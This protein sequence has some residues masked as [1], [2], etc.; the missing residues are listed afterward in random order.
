MHVTRLIKKATVGSAFAVLAAALMLGALASTALAQQQVR[1]GPARAEPAPPAKD[2]NQRALEIYEFRRN[3][4]SGPARG[5]EIYFYK[6]WMCH[7]ENAQGGAPKLVGLYKRANLISGAPV[8]DENVKAKILTGSANMPAYRHVLNEG[9]LADLMA[10]LK[11]EKCCWNSDAPP[12]N[13]RYKGANAPARATLYE[14]L[15]GGPKG[16]VKNNRGEAIEGIM[17]QLIADDTAIR[18]TVYSR[19][20]GQYEFP[21]VPTGSYTLR[22]AK[23]KEFY[24][25]SRTKVEVKGSET[26]ADITLLRITPSEFLPPF[27]EIAAQLTGSEWLQNLP[28]T[29]EEKKT[30]TVYCNFCHEYQQIFRNRYDESGWANIIFRMTHGAGSPLINIRNPG[31]LTAED[32]AKFAK[33]LAS[34]RGP[35]SKD[36]NFVVQPRPQGR[37]TRVVITEY[38][39]PRLNIS[40]HDTGGD[41]QVPGSASTGRIWYSTHRSSYVGS[42]NPNNGNVQEFRVPLPPQANA[43]PGTHWIYVDPKGKIW[44]SENWAHNI[45][46]LDPKTSDFRRV[47]WNVQEP[48]NSPMGGNY[49][50][51]EEENIWRLREGEVSRI[52][53]RDGSK[54]LAVKTKKF[55]STYGSALSFDNRYFGGGA[56]PRDGVV[57][58]DRKTG[59]LHEADTSPNSGP[60]RGEFDPEGNYWSA[61]RG[62]S[63]IK[64]DIKE[65]RTIEYPLPTPYTSLYTARSDKNG[66]I[67]AGE[68]N[69]GR[70][71][72]FDQKTEQ[73]TAYML[74][75]PY[76]MD[77]QSWIDN[78]TTPVS[79]WFIDHDGW[80]VRIQPLD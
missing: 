40:G 49:S 68:L 36:P 75:E 76:A 39:L 60:A 4:Q 57:V 58:Y 72:R 47:V 12:L 21:K 22:I 80:L 59:E 7:N 35:D 14:S 55:P 65:K 30:L 6:C 41:A 27:P 31:R 26:F 67:W 66:D 62:G 33:W 45:W 34:V 52:N 48:I 9:D 3:V 38:E 32:E 54:M 56:W 42:L 44:G 17:V 1:Q 15:T 2:Y 13:P 37:A 43:L 50:L 18:T 53:G 10:W 79:V 70:Y 19:R 63:L 64:F 78:S 77:R 28:G 29:G 16:I 25:F 74:P 23:P 24:P 11:D 61:G 71:V 8:N 46:T 69:G 73:F 5:E 51:D 20:D